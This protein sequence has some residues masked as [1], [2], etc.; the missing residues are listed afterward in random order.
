MIPHRM[1][2]ESLALQHQLASMF[3]EQVPHVGSLDTDKIF[4]ELTHPKRLKYKI[5]Q[6]VQGLK[7]DVAN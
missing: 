1:H 5:C 2:L 4:K 7:M 3:H 6:Q